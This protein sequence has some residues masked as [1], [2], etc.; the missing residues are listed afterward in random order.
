MSLKKAED[1]K[2]TLYCSFCGKSQH[3]VKKL[4][5]GPTV[6]VCDECV[7]LCFDIIAEGEDRTTTYGYALETFLRSLEEEKKA[8]PARELLQLTFEN[9]GNITVSD[10]LGK[11]SKLI[12]ATKRIPIEVARLKNE[13]ADTGSQIAA[14]MERRTQLQSELAAHPGHDVETK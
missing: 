7:H 8:L 2:N 4:I 9:L 10:L 13:L 5:A 12:L 1:H 14:L 6:F 3:E 11:I